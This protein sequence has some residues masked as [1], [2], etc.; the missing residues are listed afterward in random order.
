MFR[1]LWQE[2]WEIKSVPKPG[3]PIWQMQYLPAVKSGQ[4]SGKTKNYFI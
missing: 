2:A 4:L 3:S 1:F